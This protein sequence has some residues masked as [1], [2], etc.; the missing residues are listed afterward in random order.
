MG[1]R[2]A[3]A[4]LKGRKS[5]AL[6]DAPFCW[7]WTVRSGGGPNGPA[8]KLGGSKNRKSTAHSSSGA[9]GRARGRRFL[10]ES[11]NS[12]LAYSNSPPAG[13]ATSPDELQPAA[14]G[15]GELRDPK[16][17]QEQYPK[18]GQ[19]QDPTHR[20]NSSPKLGPAR[21]EN[22]SRFSRPK[23]SR[24]PKLAPILRPVSASLRLRCRSAAFSRALRDSSIFGYRRN[25]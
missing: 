15:G 8:H 19:K 6:F 21:C 22:R 5:S 4:T 13:S 2:P 10:A 11:C 7:F 23:N 18:H 25:S 24:S 9:G 20:P 3:R 14:W 1:R 12:L 17:S 16:G